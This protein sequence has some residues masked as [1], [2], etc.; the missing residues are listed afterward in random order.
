M[1]WLGSDKDQ[2]M[3]QIA[4]HTHLRKYPNK[5]LYFVILKA[6]SK[7]YELYQYN[8]NKIIDL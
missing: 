7:S 3:D 1:T 4:V 6:K 8:S 5:E 2:L